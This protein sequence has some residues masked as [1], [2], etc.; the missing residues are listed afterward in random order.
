ME[1]SGAYHHDPRVNHHATI[2]PL[3]LRHGGPSTRFHK[4]C[5]MALWGVVLVV[6]ALIA[7]SVYTSFLACQPHPS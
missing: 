4:A 1:P 6:A 3:L 7:W 2:A 5:G